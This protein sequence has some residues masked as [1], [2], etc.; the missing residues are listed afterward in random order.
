MKKYTTMD[1]LKQL[2]SDRNLRQVDI[3]NLCLPFCKKYGINIGKSDLSQYLSGKVVPK[4]DKLSILSMALGVSEVWLMGYDETTDK[5]DISPPKNYEIFKKNLFQ[6]CKRMALSPVQVFERIGIPSSE[7][8]KWSSE[9]Y[10][11][12]DSIQKLAKLFHVPIE[13][14]TEDQESAEKKKD[15]LNFL[16]LNGVRFIPVYENVSAGFGVCAIN[17]VVE[18][19]PLYIVNHQEANETLCIRVRGDSMS[20]KIE[21]GDII[22][23]HKQSSVD[24]GS[25]AVVMLDGEEFLVKQVLFGETWIELRSLNPLY[26]PFR[27]NGADTERV[28]IVGLVKKIIKDV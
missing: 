8:E 21:D 16:E 12:M 27:F 6:Y 14:L 4:Q 19:I 28:Q 1:R 11:S 15:N 10:P 17:D 18:Y 13:H 2:M 5:T 26:K 25:I 7:Y 9:N 22:Q 23:V 24:S 20:P 3:L